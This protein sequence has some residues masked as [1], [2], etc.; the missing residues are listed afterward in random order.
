MSSALRNASGD[1]FQW[2]SS[3]SPE[4]VANRS[5]SMSATWVR[6]RGEGR[7]DRAAP[8]FERLKPGARASPL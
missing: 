2:P 8:L 1:S 4:A 7:V 3:T 5:A 6:G